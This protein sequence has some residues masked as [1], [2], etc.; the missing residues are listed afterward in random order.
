MHHQKS[1]E[2]NERLHALAKTTNQIKDV[3]NVISDIADQTNLLA[4]NAAI[5]AARAGEHG[6]GFAVVA[7]EVRN[8]AEKTQKSL[9]E[10]NITIK[11][12]VQSV[13]DVTQQVKRDAQN[14]ET[15]VKKSTEAKETMYKAE[16]D[17]ESVAQLSRDDIENS[18]IIEDE[19]KE[20]RQMVSTLQ[21]DIARVTNIVKENKKIVDEMLAK[22]SELSR[23][24]SAG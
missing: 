4:L 7:D 6:R 11:T 24:L 13:E 2:V 9:G 17:I 22:I 16:H 8:L 21:N 5:E 23:Q 15:I 3:L 19:V 12:I 14:M 1:L 18:K 20:S 10:I